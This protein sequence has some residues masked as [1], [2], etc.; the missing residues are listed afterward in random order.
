MK[1]SDHDFKM[2]PA[3]CLR[4]GHACDAATPLD[5]NHKPGTGDVTVCIA[6]GHVMVFDDELRLRD[7]TA[8][9]QR[10]I[11]GDPRV[12]AARFAILLGRATNPDWCKEKKSRPQ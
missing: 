12:A 3:L 8:D 6:C 1:L 10:Q 7:A 9:E 2:P 4:C 11:A 5:S